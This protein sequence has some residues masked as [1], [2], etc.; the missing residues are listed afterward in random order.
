MQRRIGG[1]HIRFVLMLLLLAGC[2]RPYAE[3]PGP[4]RADKDIA[5]VTP[6]NGVK[7]HA[8]NDKVVNV[9]PDSAKD[10]IKYNRLKLLPGEYTLTLIPQGIETVA[11]FTRLTVTV[12]AGKRYR[13]RSQFVPGVSQTPGHY[14]FW[15]E[16]EK[17]GE[18]VSAIAESRNPF[19]PRD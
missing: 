18:V 4:P 10:W 11:S 12:E 1:N 14:K 13:V 7:I 17:S 6:S 5:V 2:A 8:L 19:L 16:I 9:K 3:Y 15:V